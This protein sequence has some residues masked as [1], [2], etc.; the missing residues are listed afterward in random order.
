ML[1]D[2]AVPSAQHLTAFLVPRGQEE[3]RAHVCR[4][5]GLC[6]MQC[7]WYLLVSFRH[8][9]NTIEM[10]IGCVRNMKKCQPL[11]LNNPHVHLGMGKKIT[12]G[13]KISFKAF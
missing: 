8:D 4:P 12:Q 7:S 2:H 5:L 3:S 10:A 13:I 9:G 11:R 6:D 1:R